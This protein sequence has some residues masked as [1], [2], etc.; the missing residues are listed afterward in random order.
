M[1]TTK[2]ITAINS[3][4]T[5]KQF[6]PEAANSDVAASAV[7][8]SLLSLDWGEAEQTLFE[9]P[10]ALQDGMYVR[11]SVWQPRTV[12]WQIASRVNPAAAILSTSNVESVRDEEESALLAFF[13]PEDGPFKLQQ[14]RTD[15]AAAAVTRYIRGYP[16]TLRAWKW[17]PGDVEDGFVGTHDMPMLVKGISFRCPFPWFQSSAAK[18]DTANTLD[19]TLRTESLTNSGHVRC[20]L[21]VTIHGGSGSNL[22]VVISNA[23]TGADASLVG[24]GIT[25]TGITPSGTDIVVDFYATDP[26]VFTAAQGATNLVGKV[27]AGGGIWLQR[28]ANDITHQVTAGSPSGLTI[29]FEWFELW[30]AP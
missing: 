4:G 13:N 9:Q 29:D 22:T 10:R 5:S 27:S 16:Q 17:S 8:R 7:Y 18:S 3:S 28:G 15:T 12:T 14:A 19:G 21:R 6:A 11:G 25:L 23:T 30:G 2:I 20:G 1:A 24:N 26:L